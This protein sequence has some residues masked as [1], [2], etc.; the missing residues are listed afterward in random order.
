MQWFADITEHTHVQEIKVLTCAKN[1]QNYYSQIV[2]Y[3]DCSEK[4]FDLI[5]PLIYIPK[6]V[7]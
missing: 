6:T 5:L 1:N 4:C 2:Q 7:K 3:L